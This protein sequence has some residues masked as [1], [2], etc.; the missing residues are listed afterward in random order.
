[1]SY[2][3]IIGGRKLHG[4]I[5]IHGA[6]NSVLPLLAAVYLC[7]GTSILH[8]CPKLS[9]VDASLEILQH[10]GCSV[11]REGSVVSVTSSNSPLSEIPEHLMQQMRS[12][13]VFM[14]AMIA[15]T[16]K[17]VLSLP[18]GCELG[19]RPIDIHID[20]M[21][22]L[23]V[24][25]ECEGGKLLCSAENGIFGNNIHLKFP[26]VGATENIILTASV[27]DGTTVIYNAAKEPEIAD[28]AVFL[29]KAGAKVRGFGTDTIIIEGVPKLNSAEHTV[30]PDRI[31]AA[32]CLFAVAGCGG[33]LRI[34]NPKPE[35]LIPILSCLNECG[36]DC[37][38][39]NGSLCLIS[40]GRIHNFDT[41][42]TQ[43]YPGFPTDAGPLA[44]AMSIVGKGTAVFIENIFDNRFR[45]IDELKRF[46]AN[47]KTVGRVAVIPGVAH[48]SGAEVYPHDLRGGAALTLAAME[49]YGKS[50]I[51]NI[52]F[53]DR[54]Y[55]NI[56]NIFSSLG[57]D[58]K[59]I[60]E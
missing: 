16:K 3:E 56:E 18:G 42:T 46:G 26:S 35:Q 28:L 60:Q 15:K 23:G 40:S 19:P 32:T 6:K 34:N 36:C 33:K 57:A 48:L 5:N 2:F 8:N 43:P 39:E 24:K 29:N 45:Y 17:A 13:I 4:D 44:V 11:K 30:M 37:H 54:G 21:K 41:V 58:I 22:R 52:D 51:K 10:L 9:D 50:Y 20:S 59:R 49:A 27:A 31:V 7:N 38:Y 14:G 12:S 25:V 47:I 1:M 53:I 55:E